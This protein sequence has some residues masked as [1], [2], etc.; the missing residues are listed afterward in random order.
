MKQEK[1]PSPTAP[2]RGP[3]PGRILFMAYLF[4]CTALVFT[5]PAYATTI[6]EKASEVMQDVQYSGRGH[7]ECLSC[8]QYLRLQRVRRYGQFAYLRRYSQ[9]RTPAGR[10]LS[11]P[12]G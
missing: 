8:E 4:L 9:S 10:S 11:D 6:W 2:R 1:A 12:P 3:D 7:H 5:Q